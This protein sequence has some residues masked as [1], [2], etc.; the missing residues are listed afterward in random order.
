M[1]EDYHEIYK[2]VKVVL[3]V[4]VSQME[5]SRINLGQM[6][7]KRDKLWGVSYFTN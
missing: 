2:N 7:L 4:R 1:R 5:E 3:P 6:R